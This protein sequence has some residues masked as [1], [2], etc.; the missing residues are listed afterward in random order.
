MSFG[1]IFSRG[2]NTGFF[3]VVA[4]S[5]FPGVGNSNEISFY[6]LENKRKNFFY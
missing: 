5:I 6:Q 2:A 1:K 4:K 3:Q